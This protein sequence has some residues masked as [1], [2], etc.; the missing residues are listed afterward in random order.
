MAPKSKRKRAHTEIRVDIPQEDDIVTRTE[1]AR[2]NN[3]QILTK[4]TKVSIPVVETATSQDQASQAPETEPSA[5]D[6]GQAPAA[7][8]ARKG[9][10][11][12][13]AVCSS[14]L[15]LPQHVLTAKVYRQT[16][17]SGC[18]S[19]ASLPTGS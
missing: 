10:S 4:L 12:S 16:S 3:Q 11:H 7:K 9:P 15:P 19:K 6:D 5:P 8:K 17:K 18:H 2:G 14:F 1:V 13:V